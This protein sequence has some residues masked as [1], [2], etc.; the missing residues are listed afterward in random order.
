MTVVVADKRSERVF[1]MR[2]VRPTSTVPP[3]SQPDSLPADALND[4]AINI[5]STR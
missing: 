1:E 2:L 5:V 4:K 3:R